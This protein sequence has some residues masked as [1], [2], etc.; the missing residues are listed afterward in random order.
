MNINNLTSIVQTSKHPVSTSS[1]Y[2]FIPTTRVLNIFADSG[3]YPVSATEARVKKEEFRGFQQH[4]LRL[5]NESYSRELLGVGEVL[6]E[7]VVLNSHKGDSSFRLY[8][9]LFE[10]ICSNGLIVEKEAT[11]FHSIAHRGFTDEKVANAVTC[12]VRFLPSVLARREAMQRI[13]L[14]W[15]ERIKFAAIAV[16]LRFSGGSQSVAPA[17]LLRVRHSLQSEPSLWNTFNIV[18]ENLVRGGVP[19]KGRHG[20]TFRSRRIQ[21]VGAEVQINRMLWHLA[22]SVAQQRA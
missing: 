22:E 9:A 11:D 12:L 8:A 2:S 16:E 1:K 7:I 18:Q 13:R 17:D 3:W 21:G 14:D 19:Q 15:N 4:M 5:R 6:P 10:K 20:R